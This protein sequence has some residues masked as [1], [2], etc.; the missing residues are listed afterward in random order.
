MLL[1][2]GGLAAQQA[3][4]QETA[5]RPAAAGDEGAG[6]S[7]ATV[8]PAADPTPSSSGTTPS[9]QGI[10]QALDRIAELL[11]EQ[12]A[13]RS[14][15]L[16]I[17]RIELLTRRL[18]PI[19]SSLRQVEAL[20]RE[21]N[22]ERSRLEVLDEA[23]GQRLEEASSEALSNAIQADRVQL[24]LEL[25]TSAQRLEALRQEE[26]GL[27]TEHMVLLE[28]IRRLEA[29]LEAAVAPEAATAPP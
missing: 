29:R 19:E 25:V 18:L 17:R 5:S 27:R 22:S 2:G 3:A 14:S 6:D 16:L 20:R 13:H 23:A 21:T 26:L 15:D 7:A 8:E 11:E 10:W 9:L 28:E 12:N 24:A 4:L 1:L